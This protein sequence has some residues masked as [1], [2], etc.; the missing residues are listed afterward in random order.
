MNLKKILAYIVL[1]IFIITA[2]PAGYYGSKYFYQYLQYKKTHSTV[3]TT[4][5]SEP[6]QPN[7]ESSAIPAEVNLDVHFYSQAPFANWDLPYQEACEEA[8]ITLAYNYVTGTTMTAEEF[9]AKLLE[10]VDWETEYFGYYEHTTIEET[11]EMLEINFGFTDWEI[12]EIE[13]ANDLKQLLTAGNAIVAP[14]AGRELGNPN[15]TDEG[16]Y[17][18]MMVIKGFD[19]NYFI[20]NDVGTRMGHNYQY[21]YETLLNA[22]HDWHDEDIM[23]GD[24]KILVLQTPSS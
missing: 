3:E 14:F 24:A 7:P 17:Y 15:Y 4:D 18:H 22:L 5:P 21:T 20:T 2:I 19:E 23:Q 6:F 10:L 1:P 9:D 12:V 11:A 16:P 13:T 8:S